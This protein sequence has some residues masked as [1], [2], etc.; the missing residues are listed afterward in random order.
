MRKKLVL[1]TMLCILATTLPAQ[2]VVTQ[3]SHVFFIADGSSV[4]GSSAT[5][6]R[7]D[8]HVSMRLHTRQLDPEHAYTTWWVVFNNPEACVDDPCGMQDFLNPL[9]DA[10]LKWADGEVVGSNGIATF[11]S[12]LKTTDSGAEFSQGQALTNPAGA[13]IHIVVR[14]HGESEKDSDQTTT[15]NGGCSA[16]SS[17]PGGS[18]SSLSG[19][20]ECE[21]EQFAL[22]LAP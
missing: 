12:T 18:G 14:D 7:G 10:R 5:L 2:A 21:D 1:G 16:S 8:N 3:T 15:L 6:W 17:V 20:N 11:A 4:K 19:Q 13:E 9:T 22:F